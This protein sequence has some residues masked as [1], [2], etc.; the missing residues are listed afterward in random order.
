MVVLFGAAGVFEPFNERAWAM[1]IVG[2]LY[3]LAREIVK[4]I[5]DMEGDEGRNTYAMRVGPE[6]ARV[7]AWVLLLLTLVSLLVPFGIGVFPQL[8]LVGVIPAVMLLLMVKG[9]L[10]T[11]E[12]YAAQQ[13]IKKSMYLAL[14]AFLG[15]SLLA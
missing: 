3:S 13:L 14:A 5:E 4:D 7:V 11:S 8:H 10:M 6:K 2:A 9:K 15:S 12:D 1:F